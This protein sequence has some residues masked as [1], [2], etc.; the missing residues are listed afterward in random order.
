MSGRI[1]KADSQRSHLSSFTMKLKDKFH[2]PKIIKRTP[3]KKGKSADLTVKTEEKPVNK[4]LSRLEEQEKEVVNALRY[5]KTIV[6]KMAVDKMVLVMLPGSASKVLEAI[7]PLVQADTHSQQSTAIS[8]CY[9]RVYQSLANL[10]RWSDQVMLEG[11]NCEDKEMVSTVKDVIKA[12][13]DGV[14]ELVRLMIEKQE[15][16][17]PTSPVKPTIP[18]SKS[19]STQDLPL[20]ERELEILNKTPEPSKEAPIDCVETDELAPPKPPLPGIRVMDN[21]PPPALPPKK[22]QSAPSPTRVAVVA[23]M[24]RATSGSSIPLGTS[25]QDFEVNCYA[26]RRLSGGSQSYGGESPRLSPC[27]SIGKLSKSDEQ[28]SSLDRDSGQCSRNTSCETLDNYDPDYEFLQQDLSS[29]DQVLGQGPGVLSP[30]PESLGES[31][32]PFHGQNF[33]LPPITPQ[34]SEA[35]YPSSVIETPPALPEKKRRSAVSHAS[36]G[37]RYE[38]HPS[39]Y[40]NISEDDLLLPPS[41][42]PFAAVSPFQ[43]GNTSQ[44]EFLA[45]FGAVECDDIPE[46]PPP[47][48]E[49]KNKHMMT[50]MRFVEDY[51]EPQPSVFYQTPQNEH[52]YQQKNKHLREVYGFND[53]FSGSDTGVERAPPPALPPKQRQLQASFA[54]SSFSSVSYCAQPTKGVFAPEDGSH[55]QGISLSVSNCFLSRHGSFPVPSELPLPGEGHQRA[56]LQPCV[57]GSE[58]HESTERP[59]NSTEGLDEEEQEAEE[60]EE[61][62]ELSLVDHSEIM[63]RLTLKQEGDD[64]PDV[65]GGSGDILLVHATE[66]DR[67]D[68]VLY[69]EAFLTTYRTFISPEELIQKLQYR[70]ERFCHFQDTFKQRVSKNTFF[71]LVRVVDELC[72]VEL[73]DDILKLLMELVFR[74]VCKGELSL[75]RVLRKNILEKMDNKRM[76]HHCN[77]AIRP[78]A[79]RGVAARPGTLHDFHS[80]EIAEQL[81]LLDAEL[82]YKIEIPE[83]LLWAKEQNEEKS[84]NLTQFTEHFNNMSYWVRSIIMLQEKAQDRERLLLKFIKIMKHLRKLNNFNSYLAILSA[85]DSAPIRRLEWQKQTSEGLAEYCTLI[86]SSSSF[87]A[88]RAALSDVEPP[89][90]PY[91]GLILQDLTFVHLGNPDHIDGKVNFSK[92]WQQFNILDSM[93]RFQQ[94]HYEIRR[95]DDIISFFNDF[96]D[97][98]AEEALWELSLK[99]KPRNVTRR[100]TERDEKT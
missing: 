35:S 23:P 76:Q 73:T 79:S 80:H 72:L 77:S 97:H 68:L 18:A 66:T 70:Y 51:S 17:S 71:V 46:K 8:S 86:D 31:G 45:D 26:H 99:I 4:I 20:S 84:P 49:K 94:V 95:N 64:G 41:S 75:A 16:P 65:R 50:Y 40:D 59:P 87:R 39:Q 25:T 9:S 67:K 11:V 29:T 28:L 61:A 63:A 37:S 30:L 13:L 38:R 60:S 55:P 44:V 58:N 3:S 96:S 89:C 6:D 90:I 92:R 52:I 98:L 93:R 83:V 5:F 27:S 100:K 19:D 2:S 62:D 69:C 81:T 15:R 24:S 1:E 53:S 57:P 56:L 48:P 33:Q 85:L 88:Y 47:L 42:T 14:K 21:S 82:F 10:I 91:L 34:N 36:D 78:L 54:A 22:R 7:L 74:L 43:A 12:V 32:S